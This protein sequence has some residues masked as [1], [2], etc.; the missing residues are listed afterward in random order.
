MR[1]ETGDIGGRECALYYPYQ[2]LEKLKKRER[3]K[4]NVCLRDRKGSGNGEGEMEI[5][6]I[7]GN[8]WEICTGEGYCICM[9]GT[10]S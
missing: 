5:G 1:E 3:Q 2:S 9:A 10:Q 8:C 4:K 7:R 6:D